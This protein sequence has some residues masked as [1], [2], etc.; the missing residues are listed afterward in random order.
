MK[1]LLIY[2]FSTNLHIRQLKGE[3]R[4]K[5]AMRSIFRTLRFS[6]N[7]INTLKAVITLA[8]CFITNISIS[9]FENSPKL[10][11][12][13]RLVADLVDVTED[14]LELLIDILSGNPYR[15]FK[16]TSAVHKTRE[17]NKVPTSASM[18]VNLEESPLKLKRDQRKITDDSCSY[19]Y[20]RARITT[21]AETFNCEKYILER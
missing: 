6:K 18:L 2:T 10:S 4:L 5:A 7:K 21:L 11:N 17:A 9:R 3:A 13:F 14:Q 1:S 12:S 19:T 15:I 20:L 8:V 16:A